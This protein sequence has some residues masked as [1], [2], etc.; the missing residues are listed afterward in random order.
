MP[1][2]DADTGA[3]IDDF[4]HVQQCIG[5][6]L[7]TRLGERV[8]REWVGNPG[9]RLLGENAT[10]SVVLKWFTIVYALQST[11][12]P[13]FQITRFIVNDIARNGFATF[14]MDGSYLPYALEDFVQAKLF[15]STS[16]DVVSVQAAA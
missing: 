16:G 8:M 14:T 6:L 7:T 10:Q 4:A 3:D 1:D 11:F 9:T 5:I 12:E 13:R 2:I 15:V